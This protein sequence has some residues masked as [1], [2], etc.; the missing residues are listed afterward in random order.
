MDGPMATTRTDLFLQNDAFTEW[1]DY[2][3][4]LGDP[5]FTLE[6]PP[7]DAL[8]ALLR[9]LA[10]P[11]EDFDPIIASRPDPDR[12][13][14]VWW[15]LERCVHSL[16]RHM[17]TV[18]AP[19][20][21]A[22]LR[23]INDPEHRFFY[24]HVFLAAHPHAVAYHARRGIPQE[25]SRATLA[26]LGR[27][28]RVHRKRYGIGGLGV[29]F[30]L[31]RHFRGVIYELGRLQF[32]RARLGAS[33][34]PAI[35]GAEEGD[36]GLSV[37][38]PDFLGPMTPEACDASIAR[39]KT[40]FA[41]HFPEETYAAAI[42]HSWLLDPQLREYLPDASNIIRF[43][44]RFT[45]GDHEHDVDTSIVQ[46]VFGPTPA[47]LDELPQRST[48]ERAVITHLKSGRHWKGRSG[49]FAF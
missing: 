42:C 23:D 47:N 4:A 9:E 40:F 28:V 6:L 21:F 22:P 16:V 41:A 7:P 26:D 35:P 14:E 30:W 11:D 19:P 12:D 45:L 34:A 31:M 17:G 20:T 3:T 44:D 13:P 36:L 25:I 5:P 29:A 49:W 2:L 43:Q 48:L 32:E 46:F 27:N 24:V 15:L 37:H 39:A 18:D 38:V 8:P 33:L 1:H 10:I